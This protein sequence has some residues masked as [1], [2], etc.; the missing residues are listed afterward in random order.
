MYRAF[1]LSLSLIFVAIAQAGAEIGKITE[2]NGTVQIKTIQA[3]KIEGSPGT[4]I[5][6]G[7]LVKVRKK[8]LAFIKMNDRSEF[9]IGAKTT[10]I[11]D[12]FLFDAKNQKMRARIIDGA[13]AYDGMKLVPN[14]DRQFENN[15]FTL[16]VRGTKF[17]GSFGHKSQLVL[18]EGSLV[19][20]GKGKDKA[21]NVPMQS[22]IF[23]QS[24]IGDPFKMSIEEVQVFFAINGLEISRLI[25]PDF[26]N[27]LKNQKSYCVGSN[28]GG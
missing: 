26:D 4:E 23:D 17:A 28:C 22:I 9:Q 14:D 1:L 16:T 20:E 25:G 8:S 2:S 15:G 21:L 6:V 5:N 10:L 19:V 27:S 24:G 13:L 3:E 18:L 12:D 11:F 7:D